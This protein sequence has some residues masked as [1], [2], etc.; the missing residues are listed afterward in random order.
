MAALL[1]SA[2]V[3]IVVAVCLSRVVLGV[4]YPSD[5]IAGALLGGGWAVYLWR[6]V[7]INA[8]RRDAR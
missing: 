5:V 4:H 8:P 2:C 3:L 1:A 6:C 7:R